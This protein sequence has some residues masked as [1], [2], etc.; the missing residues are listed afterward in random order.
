M[1][2]KQLQESVKASERAAVKAGM[3]VNWSSLRAFRRSVQLR[4]VEVE[5]VAILFHQ[6][7]HET[8]KKVLIVKELY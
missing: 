3:G 5:V 7:F 8:V 1:V 2:V 6:V 4:P